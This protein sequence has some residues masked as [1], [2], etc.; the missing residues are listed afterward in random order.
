MN[1][2]DQALFDRAAELCREDGIQLGDRER[3]LLELHANLVRQFNPVVSLVSRSDLASLWT[4]HIVD[5]LSLAPVLAKLGL[6]N[7]MLLDI[8]SG[9]GYPAIPLKIALPELRITMLERSERKVGF[10]R[11]VVG[12]LGLQSVDILHGEYPRDADSITPDALTAR[13]VE[14]GEELGIEIAANLAPNTVFLSQSGQPPR[15]GSIATP[16]N[17]PWTTQGL[18]RGQL[19]LIRLSQ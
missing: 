10:L 6:A 11:K 8:G 18:R 17:D 4:R 15:P 7:G 2:S 3:D 1:D 16:I 13:A 19:T 5:S 9:G 12:A 14:R